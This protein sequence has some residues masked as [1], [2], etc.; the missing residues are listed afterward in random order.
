ML[1][2]CLAERMARSEVLPIPYVGPAGGRFDNPAAPHIEL[3]LMLEGA[4]RDI[5][6]GPDLVVDLPAHHLS[7]HNVHFGNHSR[8]YNGAKC[9]CCFLDIGP[10]RSLHWMGRK[11]FAQVYPIRN[12]LGLAEAFHRM[13]ERCVAISGRAG[14][15]PHGPYGYDPQRDGEADAAKML[16]LQTSVLEV[17]GMA[18]QEMSRPPKAS[19]EPDLPFPIRLA[20]DYMGGRYADPELRLDDVA[21]AA[22]LSVDHFGRLFRQKT[23]MSPMARLQ[24]LRIDQACR[25]LDQPSLRI[26]EVADHVGFPDPFHFSRVFRKIMGIGPREYRAGR[27]IR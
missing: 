21:R 13:Q 5:H 14:S 22:H 7:V 9:L 10:D 18:W 12:P 25:L 15:Y 6:V 8:Q 23:G 24:A 3:V 1:F 27:A 2:A 20:L 11:A 17:L 19:E 16:L 4:I 26:H